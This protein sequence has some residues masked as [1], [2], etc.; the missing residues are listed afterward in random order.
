MIG[1]LLQSIVPGGIYLGIGIAIGAAFGD[2][3]RPLAK[4]M[5]KWGLVAAE[6]MQETTAEALERAQDLVA[7]ARYEHEVEA[8]RTGNGAARAGA[9]KRTRVARSASAAGE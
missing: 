4:E 6:R 9:V 3:L 8:R 1:K 7:E 2:R 5:M